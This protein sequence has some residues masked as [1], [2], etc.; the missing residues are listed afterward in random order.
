MQ[1]LCR[2]GRRHRRTRRQGAAQR[3]AAR[4][5]GE[6][7]AG[8]DWQGALD[9]AMPHLAR[10]ASKGLR[11][12]SEFLDAMVEGVDDIQ[13]AVAVEGDAVRGEELARPGPLLAEATQE[14]AV[15]G[16]LLNATADGADP[17]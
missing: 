1:G 10:R 2:A 3:S 11:L 8:P 9:R 17:D 5:A 12:D 7:D 15:L 4:R 6:E 14:L 13:M 16:E